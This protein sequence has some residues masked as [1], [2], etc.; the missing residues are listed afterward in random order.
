PAEPRR[1]AWARASWSWWGPLLMIVHDLDVCWAFRRPNEAH[2]ELVVDTDR[3]LPP[4]VA[5]ECFKAIAWR[6]PQVAELARGVEIAQFPA[7]HLDQVSR[8]AL[9]TFAVEDRFGGLVP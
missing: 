6:G 7:R 4:P 2:A 3:V 5:R 8:K 1:D 9:W